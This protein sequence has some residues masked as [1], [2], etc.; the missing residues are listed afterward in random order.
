[1]VPI[2]PAD[3]CMGRQSKHGPACRC[4]MHKPAMPACFTAPMRCTCSRVFSTSKGHTK[5]AVR[6]PAQHQ[7]Q[8]AFAV[9]LSREQGAGST[10][11]GQRPAPS[12][13]LP[14]PHTSIPVTWPLPAKAPDTALMICM[15]KSQRNVSALLK[16]AHARA[17]CCVSPE[18]FCTA[19][20]RDTVL[21]WPPCSPPGPAKDVSAKEMRAERAGKGL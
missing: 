7:V 6:A 11:Q 1:M 16:C 13:C 3:Q 15:G 5:V 14:S 10:S 21:P 12:P 20:A 19:A 17:V 2:T 8:A 4:A 18:A 9:S